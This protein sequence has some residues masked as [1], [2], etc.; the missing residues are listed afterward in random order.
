MCVWAGKGGLAWGESPCSS[1]QARDDGTQ[2]VCPVPTLE[3]TCQKQ[4]S[5]GTSLVV[6]WLGLRAS[7]AGGAGSLPGW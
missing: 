7:T 5:P 4:G 1:L 6:Q 2:P 3:K